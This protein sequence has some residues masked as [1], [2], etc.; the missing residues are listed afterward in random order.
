V[1]GARFS[2]SLSLARAG[3]RQARMT[4]E[5]CL[6]IY[7]E[8]WFERDPARRIDVLRRC[9]TEDIVF[10]DSSGRLEGLEAVSDMIGRAIGG[11]SAGAPADAPETST[12]ERRGRSGSGVSVEV[13]TPIEQL[14]GFFR[15]SFVWK[16]PD[17]SLGPGTDFCE[18]ADDGRMRLITVWPGSE[19]FPVPDPSA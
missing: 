19:Y 8:A 14:H 9:C 17:G 2:F 12:A 11:M 3:T 5:E 7:G 15:Y 18:I 1:R 4:P 13:V 16:L 6:V 10:V